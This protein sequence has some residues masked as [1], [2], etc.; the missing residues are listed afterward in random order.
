MASS[1]SASWNFPLVHGQ[2]Y[3]VRLAARGASITSY[4][5]GQLV[6]QATDFEMK[7]GKL[8]FHAWHSVTRYRV[9]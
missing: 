1:G 4:I 5:E 9:L 3:H 7:R 6:N 8:G 2:E